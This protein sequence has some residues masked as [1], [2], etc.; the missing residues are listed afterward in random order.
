MISNRF[1]VLA[2][3]FCF[4]CG[5]I[6]L[7]MHFWAQNTS[8]IS[9]HR[10]NSP[11][12]SHMQLRGLL[13]SF[14]YSGCSPCHFNF[15][16]KYAKKKINELWDFFCLHQLFGLIRFNTYRVQWLWLILL[17]YEN[18]WGAKI[19]NRNNEYELDS[20]AKMIN[21]KVSLTVS[22]TKIPVNAS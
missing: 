11:S 21:T 10:Q 17:W 2:F 4:E 7:Q 6:E 15:N 14:S 16:I 20:G 5:Q 3:N 19:F 1:Y 9:L 8:V 22:R 12:R 13:Y 18:Y